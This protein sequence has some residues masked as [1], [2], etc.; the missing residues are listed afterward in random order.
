MLIKA[1]VVVGEDL[2]EATV[3]QVICLDLPAT[4]IADVQARITE[5]EC[6]VG[7]DQ[8][9]IR[10]TLHKQI[11]YVGP[12]NRVYHQAEDVVFTAAANVPGAE[13]GMNCQVHPTI[14]SI[15]HRLIGTLPTREVRQRIILTFFVKITEPQ[16]LNVV[17][18]TTG[19]LYKVQR[20]VGEE[21]TA[22]VVESVVELPFPAEKIRAVRAVV[23]E[24]TATAAEDQVII[25][26][27]LHKQ[28]FFIS[29]FDHM[30]YH[31][32]EDVPFTA[33]VPIAGVQP[34][35][36]VQADLRVSRVT[37]RLD[38]TELDQRVVLA[39]FVKVSETAQTMLCTT[40]HG[41]LIKVGR[42]AGENT[43]Q[44]IIED[45]VCLDV[46]ARKVQDILAVITE[47]ES[48]V[49]RGKVLIE[50]T[51]HKQIFFVGPDDIVRHQ[52]VD[53]PFS[54]LVEVSHA[55]PGM[56]AQV[57]PRIEHIN[58]VLIRETPDCPL[59]NNFEP[60]YV[61]LFRVVE[62]RIVLEIFVKVTETV[63]IN[64]CIEDGPP[65]G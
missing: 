7:P 12:E 47:I 13:P 41:P 51:I 46:P 24:F 59:D 11:F 40:P 44:V 56:T 29:A 37:W 60:P 52:A 16:Q 34:G 15:D 43:K 6:E 25:E 2:T 1:D 32:S 57:H 61:D 35:E 42:V 5:L 10:G 54:A 33:V 48:Q 26:G 14:S 31:E 23:S 50:G 22:T 38:G 19:P 45:Q 63:Q 62:Q 64:V 27:L 9:V 39:I 30:E 36:H 28:I 53:V 21:T 49:I 17:L 58:W 20:V 4:K 65:L 55:E 18:G 3:D 8:A